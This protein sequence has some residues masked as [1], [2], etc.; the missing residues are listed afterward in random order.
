MR[1][2]PLVFALYAPLA[3]LAANILEVQ[4]SA[5]ARSILVSLLLGVA[6]IGVSRV[7]LRDT[8]SAT[9]LA[10]AIVIGFFSYGHLYD[11]LKSLGPT[12]I[13]LARHRYLTL[14]A[15][16]ILLG[17]TFL[18]SR[19]T[20]LGPPM[21][22][23]LTAFGWFL[24]AFPVATLIY[25]RIREM[26]TPPPTLQVVQGELMAPREDLPDVYYVILDGYGRQDV[27][28]ALFD[29]DNRPFLDFLRSRGFSVADRAMSNYNFT[30]YSLASSLNM[31]YLGQVA[32]QDLSYRQSVRDYLKGNQVFRQMRSLGYQVVAFDTGFSPTTFDGADLFL[33]P[34]YGPSSEEERLYAN[35]TLNEFEGLLLHTTWGRAVL[36]SYA[37][38]IRRQAP[39]LID[40]SYE[41]HRARVLFTIS[42]LSEIA[43]RPGAYF[44]M[45]HVVAPHPPFV[46]GPQGQRLIQTEP[47]SLSEIGCCEQ[48]EYVSRYRDQVE[49]VNHL[50][51][52]EID[53]ILRASD[54]PPIILL[55]GDHGPGGHLE[56][57][58]ASR[59]GM[60]ARMAILSAYYLPDGET[61]ALNPGITPVNSF[62][63]IFNQLFGAKFPSLDDVSYFLDL[64]GSDATVI[65]PPFSMYDD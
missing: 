57:Q 41:K 63:L 1:T 3:L 45:A 19:R 53:E 42:S 14:F 24:V 46:F 5:A 62:R 64:D 43:Q 18:L 50:L 21:A 60:Q 34:D 16:A 26:E 39:G 17:L 33:K 40:F 25:S 4:P 65:V 13:S 44:V 6:A 2:S 35:L 47:F 54:V 8:A 12:G 48:D 29:Y 58:S 31:A 20:K 37:R 55:Q 52:L 27:L 22:L 51:R 38:E 7:L 28:S 11:G 30:F 56:R 49:Y 23:W 36:D 61:G 9:V 10:C 15:L 59:L 32:H